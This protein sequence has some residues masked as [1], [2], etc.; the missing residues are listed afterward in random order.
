[1]N[2]ETIGRYNVVLEV[3]TTFKKEENEALKKEAQGL[4]GFFEKA[5]QSFKKVVT[6]ESIKQN[7]AA[8]NKIKLTAATIALELAK[9][10]EKARKFI[11]IIS[12]IE[13]SKLNKVA[14][15][16]G[17]IENELTD[18]LSTVSL[19]DEQMQVLAT[20]AQDVAHE[21]GKITD[22]SFSEL[23][24]EIGL[25]TGHFLTADK[26]LRAITDLINSGKLSGE[27]LEIAKKRAAELTKNIGDTREQLKNMAS[28][29]GGLDTII[30]ATRLTAAGFG[31]A[32]SATA[33]FGQESEEIQKTLT[34]L[35]AIMALQNSLHEA[36]Q[37]LLQNSNLKMRA[38][39]AGQAI[40]NFVVGKSTGSLK[41]FRIAL[42]STGIGL[43]V[44][45]LGV[46]VANWDKLKNAIAENAD[47]IF[48]FAKNV[49]TFMPPLNMLIRG[50]EWLYNN[51]NKLDN[52]IAGVA[53]SLTSFLSD[54]GDV[55][56]KLGKGDFSGAYKE[57]KSIGANAGKAFKQGFD[58]ATKKDEIKALVERLQKS[59]E[60]NKLY[61]DR[62]D[63][64]GKSSYATR[65]KILEDE[66]QVLKLSN[67][68]KK[69]IYEK[70]TELIELETER[71]KEL[72]EHAKDIQKKTLDAEIESMEKAYLKKEIE[73]KKTIKDEDKLNKEIEKLSL[74][75]DIAIK[76]A[77][78]K[79]LAENTKEWLEIQSSLIDDLKK[80]NNLNVRIEP[81]IEFVPQVKI[82][83]QYKEQIDFIIDQYQ[84]FV[85]LGK[86]G[87]IDSK[88]AKDAQMVISIL[89][90]MG[91]TAESVATKHTESLEKLTDTMINNV[92]KSMEKGE[93]EIKKTFTKKLGEDLIKGLALALDIPHEKMEIFKKDMEMITSSINS[94]YH[95]A[96]ENIDIQIE[97]TDVLK[98]KQ[99]ERVDKAAQLAE[100]G[101][102][103]QLQIEEERLSQL[104]EKREKYAKKQRALANTEIIVK[105]AVALA[106]A[107]EAVSAGFASG[108][109]PLGIATGIAIAAQ[110]AAVGFAINNAFA[111][112]PTNIEGTEL[113]QADPRYRNNKVRNG[114]D[115]YIA[116]FD[117]NERIVDPQTNQAL[118]NFPNSLLPNA[119]QAYKLI[120]HM[121]TV[122]R[123]QAGNNNNNNLKI[124]SLEKKMDEVKKSI[125]SIKIV[126]KFDK[127]G[128]MQQ[129]EREYDKVKRRKIIRG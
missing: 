50:I 23:S 56:G 107:I 6:D 21:L 12:Q 57:F 4:Q 99:E 46:L 68:D 7:L 86:L 101:K 72:Q 116:R 49:T 2:S 94:M 13:T 111:D 54:I 114:E 110:L 83:A 30:E 45:A 53:G 42:A 61:A 103:K 43:L 41:I 28:D 124:E 26:E 126:T 14:I 65:K 38:L 52:I 59:I 79:R 9:D 39:A 51:L 109:I 122:L 75:R 102:V 90:D 18:L 60:N 97:K 115:G 1:M 40:Y 25:L 121:V 70:E 19:T 98:S 17:K 36:H 5:R 20:N 64:L 93:K 87:L 127:D 62:L 32:Q 128:F 96:I 33:L 113:V 10:Q 37:L 48:R 44:L 29:T 85:D 123:K 119:V 67:A 82:A 34:K 24:D 81:K 74:E 15:D 117:G 66:L 63:A 108:N 104:Q 3:I 92:K 91:G 16:A 112:I 55:I 105:N 95:S 8:L 118:G 76:K 78:Q 106:N 71:R 47:K 69:E 77:K 31:I 120:P 100:K 11:D 27:K 88:F 89:S 35:A 84:K 58:E 129:I 73:L 125:E 22:S 80:L